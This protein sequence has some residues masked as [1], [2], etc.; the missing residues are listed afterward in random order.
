MFER[1]DP[2][3][4]RSLFFAR[5]AVS[6]HGGATIDA[7]HLLIGVLHAKPEAVREFASNPIEVERVRQQLIAAVA[8]EARVATMHEITFSRE[9]VEVFERAVNEAEDASN[10][11]VKPEHLMLGILTKTQGHAS[12]LLIA[13]G[14]RVAAIRQA[15]SSR[16]EE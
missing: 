14:V 13:A 10:A 15:L 5:K 6:D 16:H 9:V 4:A 1:F 2:D 7:E 12:A 8:S 3:A 11:S